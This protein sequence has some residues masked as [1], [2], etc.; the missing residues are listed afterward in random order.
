MQN[1]VDNGYIT[2]DNGTIDNTT[3]TTTQV[4]VTFQANNADAVFPTNTQI[5]EESGNNFDFSNFITEDVTASVIQNDLPNAISAVRIGIPN[6]KLSFS[7]NITVTMDVTSPHN[8]MTMEVLYKKE[9]ETTYTKLTDCTITNSTCT[10]T[11]NHATTYVVNGDGTITGTDQKNISATVQENLTLSCANLDIDGGTPI[12]A[13]GSTIAAN[14]TQCQVTTNDKDGYHLQI[15]QDSSLTHTDT[16]TLITDKTDWDGT[17]ATSYTP[18]GL[19]FRV[20]DNDT[21]AMN[22]TWWGTS[23]NCTATNINELF[24][25]LPNTLQDI[26]HEQDYNNTTSTTDICYAVSVPSTQKSGE[27]TG[28]VTYSVTT[29]A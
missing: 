6:E 18:T 16:T 23:T 20:S 15:R 24:A 26:V 19:A 10:F 3:Q 12:V 21:G 2:V 11:T 13:D 25:G 9:G 7:Q 5:T 8:G 14:T 4:Q 28:T 29:G 27:Y 17:N 22:T 1:A